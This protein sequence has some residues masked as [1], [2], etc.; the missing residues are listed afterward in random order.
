MLF[1]LMIGQ[2]PK[3]Q[4]TDT[5]VPYNR[6]LR[7]RSRGADLPP[8][9]SRWSGTRRTREGRPGVAVGRNQLDL[10][11]RKHGERLGPTG[12][13]PAT[14]VILTQAVTPTAT[15]P[16]TEKAI[17]PPSDGLVRRLRPSRAWYTAKSAGAANARANAHRRAADRHAARSRGRGQQAAP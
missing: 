8:C 9:G 5:L 2:P 3:S 7:A 6:L 12:I 1:Y 16:R 4:R 15:A 17:C 13:A 10:V 11:G 14:A